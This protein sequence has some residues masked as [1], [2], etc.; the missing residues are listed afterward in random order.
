MCFSSRDWVLGQC[1]MRTSGSYGG[2]HTPSTALG[3]TL[4]V[5]GATEGGPDA[6]KCKKG[7]LRGSGPTLTSARRRET[8]QPSP[9]QKP[10]G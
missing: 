6:G 5:V 2:K 9:R 10:Q 1:W 3:V 8:I 4:C 7:T